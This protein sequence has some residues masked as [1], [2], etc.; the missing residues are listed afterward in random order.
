MWLLPWIERHD[1]TNNMVVWNQ[2]REV[3]ELIFVNGLF[4][5]L[6]IFGIP[7]ESSTGNFKREFP[8]EF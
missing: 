6:N 2:K 1:T 3:Q 5:R 8:G 7:L 4:S